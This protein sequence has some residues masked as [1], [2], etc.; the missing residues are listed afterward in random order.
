M[1][2]RVDGRYLPA[3]FSA[4]QANKPALLPPFSATHCVTVTRVVVCCRAPAAPHSRRLKFPV[5]HV[6]C[7]ARLQVRVPR[8]YCLVAL[9][10]KSFHKG[11]AF[12]NSRNA[13]MHTPPPSMLPSAKRRRRPA[14]RL[15]GRKESWVLSGLDAVLR[16]VPDLC[17]QNH[18]P[19]EVEAS[20]TSTQLSNEEAPLS[21]SSRTKSEL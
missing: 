21:F 7:L 16:C 14:P 19:R 15:N 3:P 8:C 13:T 20:I 2:L 11:K 5:I 18:E 10:E 9:Q 1:F 17:N 6:C 12:Q 4:P